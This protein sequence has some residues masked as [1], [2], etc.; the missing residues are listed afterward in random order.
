MSINMR[1][2]GRRT[3]EVLFGMSLVILCAR[4]G[5]TTLYVCSGN[6]GTPPYDRPDTAAGTIQAAVD[7]AGFRDVVK[8]GP[9]L[10]IEQVVLRDGVV[11]WGSGRDRTVLKQPEDAPY[12]NVIAGAP[13]TEIRGIHIVSPQYDEFPW[14]RGS[15]V[16]LG[17]WPGQLLSDCT[18]SGPFIVA[19]DCESPMLGHPPVLRRCTIEGADRG[20]SVFGLWACCVV[21]DCLIRNNRVC[22]VSAGSGFG[23][24]RVVRSTVS[25]STY[26]IDIRGAWDV[27]VESCT[28]ENNDH[29][30]VFIEDLAV[31][32]LWSTVISGSY[33]GILCS[34]DGT[35]AVV[36]CTVASNR[37][38]IVR[39]GGLD[40]R[41]AN[42][43][44]W[45]GELPLVYVGSRVSFS[46]IEGGCD[47]E[48][49]ID[50]DPLF[51]DASAGDFRL[52][53]GSPCIDAGSNPAIQEIR[54][55]W[56]T[57][58]DGAGRY[59]RLY[60]GKER[61]VD[62]GAYEY[63]IN[64]VRAGP[65]SDEATLTWS[66]LDNSFYWIFHSDDLLTWHLAEGSVPSAGDTTTSWTDDGSLTGVPPS[67]V[68]RRFYRVCEKE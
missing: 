56:W 68:P 41:V 67:L 40:V 26:G 55:G 22:G 28:V 13:D 9:G 49:N 16:Y 53:P 42:S 45:G 34:E 14:S 27:S 2:T 20:V 43:I 30:G 50:S 33:T 36:N 25:G 52:G 6:K 46:D 47:G 19:V 29:H 10:Y 15:G 32:R 18:V 62:M 48:G 24:V 8:V 5:A 64:N 12:G 54:P 66:S 57:G 21:E 63:Y 44:V 23:T 59:R 4:G 11:L 7:A 3:A 37:H 51:M 61:E 39:M 38:G 65:G 17:P 31:A 58:V 60:G 35:V 1:H